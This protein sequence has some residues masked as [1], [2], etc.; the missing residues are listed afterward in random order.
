MWYSLIT[1][2]Q[3]SFT[4]SPHD[5]IFFLISLR[6]CRSLSV[7]CCGRA[8]MLEKVTLSAC[9]SDS[10]KHPESVRQEYMCTCI[11]L[12]FSS[13]L[14]DNHRAISV[15]YFPVFLL[16]SSYW[17][18]GFVSEPIRGAVSV[19]LLRG[20][21]IQLLVFCSSLFLFKH[22]L[23]DM[24][25]LNSLENWNQHSAALWMNERSF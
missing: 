10:R 9:C 20:P 5:W 17:L 3:I 8:I 4:S 23:W 18:K 16:S 14:C 13:L 24:S 19:I 15:F 7:A 6:L 21:S 12:S 25:S 11:N 22:I 2:W 1:V